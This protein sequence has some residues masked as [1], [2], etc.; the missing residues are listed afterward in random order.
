MI[1]FNKEKKPVILILV[2]TSIAFSIGYFLHP[3]RPGVHFFQLVNGQFDWRLWYD[4]SQYYHMSQTIVNGTF[5]SSD[6]VYGLGYPVLGIPFGALEK[7]STAFSD[8][9]FFLPNLLLLIGI[10]YITFDYSNHLNK[11][12][13]ISILCVILLLF[14]TV[15]LIWFIEPWNNHV[16]SFAVLAVFYLLQK[17]YPNV[18]NKKIIL[19]GLIAGLTF[20]SRYIDVIWLMPMFM[21]FLFFKPKKVVYLI[22]GVIII[23]V[24]L[25]SHS[26][27]FDDP[28]RLPNQ[29]V[30]FLEDEKLEMPLYTEVGLDKF[31]TDIST[32]GI[33]TFCIFI[34]PTY[35]IPDLTGNEFVDAWWHNALYNKIPILANGFGILIFSPLGIWLFFRKLQ[36][37][38]KWIFVSLIISFLASMIFY[39]SIYTYSSGL[40]PF[41]RYHLFW[42]PIF[43]IFSIYGIRHVL[44]KIKFSQ[45]NSH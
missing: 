25:F 23:L 32:I 4:Q 13:K 43:L 42:L 10:A 44:T 17:N 30:L 35:C 34:Y 3:A 40:T 21:T 27:F 24:V 41:F 19:A 39:T 31:S 38:Q 26:L 8:H 18:S 36:G 29:Y 1:L 12:T 7:L 6:Y 22:P 20:S 14:S 37:S 33:R 5:S 2:I 15:F 9:Q 28:L 45:T 11:N 16:L